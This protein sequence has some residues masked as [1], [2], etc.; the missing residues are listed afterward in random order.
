MCLRK[1][2]AL[3]WRLLNLNPVKLLFLFINIK[4][5]MWKCQVSLIKM[6]M[7]WSN[8][9]WISESDTCKKLDHCF[10]V[11]QKIA[12]DYDHL[13]FVIRQASL[14]LLLILGVKDLNKSPTISIKLWCMN[15]ISIFQLIGQKWA[16]A[17]LSDQAYDFLPSRQ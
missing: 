15:D 8:T 12:H 17:F 16:T 1:R 9:D 5:Y 6:R 7:K 4:G 3:L 13:E 10:T 11:K 2:E 14:L